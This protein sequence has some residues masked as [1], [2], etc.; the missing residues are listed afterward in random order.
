VSSWRTKGKKN[1]MPDFEIGTNPTPAPGHVLTQNPAL[2]IRMERI[3]MAPTPI[4]STV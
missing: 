4:S 1:R 3:S 2:S